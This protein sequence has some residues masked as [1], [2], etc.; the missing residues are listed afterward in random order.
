M[1]LCLFRKADMIS[2]AENIISWI[3]F[4]GIHF[5]LNFRIAKKL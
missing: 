2:D 1:Y 5:S 4:S 3:H